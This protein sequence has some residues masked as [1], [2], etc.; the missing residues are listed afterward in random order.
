MNALL[1]Q[2]HAIGFGPTG[3]GQTKAV[4]TRAY[5]IGSFRIDMAEM[6]APEERLP[7]RVGI[8]RITAS[9]FVDLHERATC[10]LGGDSPRHMI[11][12]VPYAPSCSP[13]TTRTRRQRRFGSFVH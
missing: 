6:H 2:C 5:S 7:Q 3:R 8:R 13:I 4:A 1:R 9:A 12:A 10:R 11:A